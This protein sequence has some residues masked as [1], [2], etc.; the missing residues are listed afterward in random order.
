MKILKII[1]FLFCFVIF[2]TN[3]FAISSDEMVKTGVL[4]LGIT[5]FVCG[6]II[7]IFPFLTKIGISCM[8]IGNAIVIYRIIF[9]SNLLDLICMS[10]IEKYYLN[11][12]L[13]ECRIL[14]V[15]FCIFFIFF[16]FVCRIIKNFIWIRFWRMLGFYKKESKN[17]NK[18]E[19]DKNEKL[20][21]NEKN[22]KIDNNENDV[23]DNSIIGEKTKS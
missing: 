18:V 4:D 23:L 6:T 9:Y 7:L 21:D 11:L 17:D 16:L 12:S 22:D 3:S 13:N 19:N 2:S 1:F 14:F 15:I 5:F 8:L 10:D 20:Y